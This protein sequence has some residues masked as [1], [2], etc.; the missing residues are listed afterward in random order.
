MGTIIILCLNQIARRSPACRLATVRLILPGSSA[1]CTY[2][3]FFDSPMS[4]MGRSAFLGDYPASF[5]PFASGLW[6]ERNG[7]GD[8]LLR[9]DTTL[10]RWPTGIDQPMAGSG[11]GSKGWGRASV[12]IAVVGSSMACAIGQPSNRT[13]L[14]WTTTNGQGGKSLQVPLLR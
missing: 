14:P 2:C 1:F 13:S 4:L 10:R 9:N 12:S 7:H 11:G 3:D 6:P 5:V 8:G